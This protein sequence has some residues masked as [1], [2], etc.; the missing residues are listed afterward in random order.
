MDDSRPS[1]PSSLTRLLDQ[2]R[3]HMR[4]SGYAWKTEK[5]YVHWI[6]RFILF[7]RKQHPSTL[8]AL[9]INQF[10]SMLANERHCALSTQRIALSEPA[11]GSYRRSATSEVCGELA[12]IHQRWPMGPVN[13]HYCL[14]PELGEIG[15]PP[16]GTSTALWVESGLKHSTSSP[17]SARE[18]T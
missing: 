7:H 14:G 10:L 3:R 4:D 17:T 11:C 9:H 6:R 12:V 8:S 18:G 16:Q 13:S 5:T 1:I 15:R 2:L